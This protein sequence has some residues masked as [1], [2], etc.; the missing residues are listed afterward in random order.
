MHA[1]WNRI[2]RALHAVGDFQARLILGLLY[3]VLVL[4]TG[5]I[6]RLGGRLLD[7]GTPRSASFWHPRTTTDTD[8]RRA[9]R[10]G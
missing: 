5:L 7:P 6:S 4:P 3:V 2:R 1:V 8:L 9:R 10:Q